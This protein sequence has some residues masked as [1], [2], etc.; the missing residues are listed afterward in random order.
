MK[1]YGRGAAGRKCRKRELSIRFTGK[2]A[3]YLN[4]ARGILR[5][6]KVL[7][8]DYPVLGLE[9]KMGHTSQTKDFAVVS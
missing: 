5:A 4:G 2:S 1:T 8:R 7:M 9:L 3:V 6:P